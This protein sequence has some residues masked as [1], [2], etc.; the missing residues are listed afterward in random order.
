MD[1][2]WKV[3]INADDCPIQMW[4][5]SLTINMKA[6]YINHELWELLTGQSKYRVHKLS[7]GDEVYIAY[8]NTVYKLGDKYGNSPLVY[9]EIF[10]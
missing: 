8:T 9:T 5:G 6:D 4:D 7:V 3:E 1:N 10:L 2:I